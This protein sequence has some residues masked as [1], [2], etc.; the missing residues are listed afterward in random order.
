[1]TI[2][3]EELDVVRKW[4]R[5]ELGLLR[6]C[7]TDRVVDLEDY[8]SLRQEIKKVKI[9][10]DGLNLLKMTSIR[11]KDPEIRIGA[12]PPFFET[13]HEVMTNQRLLIEDWL[14]NAECK[15]EE[16]LDL[17]QELGCVLVVYRKVIRALS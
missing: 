14:A 1:M 13:F 5:Q 6:L 16:K 9:A 7:K 11:R 8:A 10:L 2:N 3:V 12:Y 4:Y 17:M 15:T